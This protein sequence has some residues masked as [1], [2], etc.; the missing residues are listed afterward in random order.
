MDKSQGEANDQTGDAAIFLLGSDTENSQNED[1]GQDDLDDDGFDG[2]TVIEA[3]GTEAISLTGQ[4]G[5]QTRTGDTTEELGA[6]V[7]NEI[8]DAHFAAAEHGKRNCRVDVAS[9]DVTDGV[10]HSD[11]HQTE[12]QRSDQV[13]G[14]SFRGAAGNG[15]GSAGK[16]D[17]DERPD[18]L[19]NIFF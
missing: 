3:I 7:T 8:S 2:G 5:Q 16:K 9:G 11:D 18:K 12:S 13:S 19:S 14:I 4:C 15:S 1:T 10:S 6:N 17:Q